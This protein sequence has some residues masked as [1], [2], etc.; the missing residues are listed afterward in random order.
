VTVEPTWLQNLTAALHNGDWAGAGGRVLREWTCSAPHWLSVEGPYAA[1]GWP[2]V[3]F[4]QGREASELNYAPCGTNMAFRREMF[5]KYGG[6]RTD[7]GPHP[8][9]EARSPDGTPVAEDKEFGERLMAAGE[10]LRYEPSAVVYHPVLENRLTKEYFLAWWF[11]CGR[12]AIRK[13]GPRPNIWGFPRHYLRM[14]KMFTQFAGRTGQ[15]MLA[16]KAQQRFYY[17]VQVWRKAGE[18]MEGYRLWFSATRYPIAQNDATQEN[19]SN[20]KR[21]T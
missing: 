1:M 13:G 11:D 8:G 5:L 14:L 16:L 21:V 3:H 6:F 9:S 15:W 19:T 20:L 12:G 10:R 7:L 2:L 17:K 18:I 4:D